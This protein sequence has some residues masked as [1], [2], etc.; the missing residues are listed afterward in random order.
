[1]VGLGIVCV[2][3]LHEYNGIVKVSIPHSNVT[4]G[5]PSKSSSGRLFAFVSIRYGG[6]SDGQ[7]GLWD[8]R[9]DRI[10][11]HR[12]AIPMASDEHSTIYGDRQTGGRKCDVAVEHHKKFW[13]SNRDFELCRCPCALRAETSL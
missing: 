5:S 7:F 1:M 3:L 11:N 9:T 8:Q 4:I 10:S 12:R 6:D 2:L 13:S